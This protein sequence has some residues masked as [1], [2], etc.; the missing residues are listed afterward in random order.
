MY[1]PGGHLHRW[2]PLLI[3]APKAGSKANPGVSVRANTRLKDSIRRQSDVATPDHWTLKFHLCP[4]VPGGFTA[5]RQSISSGRSDAARTILQSSHKVVVGQIAFQPHTLFAGSIK[6]EHG[7]SPYR[8]EAVEPM[9][10]A[11]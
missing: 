10:D 1:S 8:I 3:D 4:F 11:L 2:P 7:R 5:G 9:A 6:Q